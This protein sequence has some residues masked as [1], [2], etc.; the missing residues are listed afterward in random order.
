[1]EKL[2]TSPV[3]L[4]IL[5]VLFLIAFAIVLLIF[6]KKVFRRNGADAVSYQSR[7]IS[8]GI[9]SIV[10]NRTLSWIILQ[11]V[12]FSINNITYL[13]NHM[14][15]YNS[16]L[17]TDQPGVDISVIG[18]SFTYFFQYFPLG[19]FLLAIGVAIVLYH[20]VVFCF[21]Q[22]KDS[23]SAVPTNQAQNA[24]L[25]NSIIITVLAFSLFLVVSVFISIPYLNEIKKPSLFSKNGLDSALNSIRLSDSTIIKKDPGISPFPITSIKDSVLKDSVTQRHY[26]VLTTATKRELDQAITAIDE[27]AKFFEHRRK[28]VWNRISNTVDQYNRDKP[29]NKEKLVRNFER[30]AQSN[31]VDKD[32][33][34]TTSVNVYQNY[35]RDFRNSLNQASAQFT[36]NDMDNATKYTYLIGRVRLAINSFFSVNDSLIDGN[37]VSLIPPAQFDVYENDNLDNS[38]NDVNVIASKRDGSDWGFFGLIARFL[39]KTESLD[40]VLLIGMM[41]F[42]LLGASFSSF[43]TAP[44]EQEDKSKNYVSFIDTFKTKPI[45]KDFWNVLAR[46]FSAAILI[47]LATKGGIAIITANTSADPNGYV[48]LFLCF[49]GAVFSEKV[50]AKAKEKY[51]L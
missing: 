5:Q 23:T 8:I 51:N 10:F 39:I 34:Y 30:Y 25:Y 16:K 15:A 50:W 6:L 20:F 27:E 31:A 1:M 13:L 7:L 17:V 14:A 26:A 32:L 9:T 44:V 37:H 35:I 45:I 36:E 21:A 47:Y 38:L 48:L 46:G 33:L 19:K 43:Q 4:L 11:P 12:I 42:G 41:G 40:L 22:L 18:S 24:F 3:F 2:F 29:A 28:E 49:I